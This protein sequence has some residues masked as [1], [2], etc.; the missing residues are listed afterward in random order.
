MID[1]TIGQSDVNI[2]PNFRESGRHIQTYLDKLLNLKIKRAFFH[3][4]NPELQSQIVIKIGQKIVCKK[5]G[6]LLMIF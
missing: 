2:Y 3:L 5:T 4:P 1:D 6:V